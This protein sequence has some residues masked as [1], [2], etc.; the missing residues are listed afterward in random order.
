VSSIQQALG[1]LF[2]SLE[3]LESSANRQEHKAV[4]VR[5]QDQQDL[6]SGI[7]SA[8]AVDPALVARKLDNTIDKIEKLLREG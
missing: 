8:F 5:K 6:F 1:G 3:R 2:D 7:A 4:K